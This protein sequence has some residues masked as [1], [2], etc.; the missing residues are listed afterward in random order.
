[1]FS[2]LLAALLLGEVLRPIQVLGIVLVLSAIV[3]V[4]RPTRS[5]TGDRVVVEPIE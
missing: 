2:I 5:V 1:V 3:I 4:Q